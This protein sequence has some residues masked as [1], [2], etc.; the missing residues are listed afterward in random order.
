MLEVKGQ[1]FDIW[2]LQGKLRRKLK[3]L[4]ACGISTP[5]KGCDTV[6]MLGKKKIIKF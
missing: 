3:P 4:P 6:R 5:R 1:I 2:T